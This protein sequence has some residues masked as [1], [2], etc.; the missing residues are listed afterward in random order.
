MQYQH[1]EV[2]PWMLELE[3]EHERPEQATLVRPDGL[4]DLA[5]LLFFFDLFSRCCGGLSSSPDAM[6]AR[7]NEV[8][9][10]NKARRWG[11]NTWR[12]RNMDG[13]TTKESEVPA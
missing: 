6:V 5:G 13:W 7:Q 3:L 11:T 8:E 10:S 12:W 4:E 2:D 1:E 9:L